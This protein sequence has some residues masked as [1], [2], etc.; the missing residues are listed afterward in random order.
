M[1]MEAENSQISSV[2]CKVET[3]ET[4]WYSSS[5]GLSLKAGKINV[6]AQ[7]S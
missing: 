6:P 2:V 3:Q 4:W 7:N 1:I 5:L